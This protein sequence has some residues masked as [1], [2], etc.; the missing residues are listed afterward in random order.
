MARTQL[1][2]EHLFRR[3]GF[4]ASPGELAALGNMSMS[5]GIS[6]LLDYAEQPD[7][8]DSKIGQPNYINFTSRALSG[9]NIIIED[10]RQRWLFRMIHSQRPLQEKMALFWHNHFATAYSKIAGTFGAVQATKMLALREGDLPGPRGQ[11]ETFRAYALGNFRDLLLEM[12]KDPAMLVWL[13][14]R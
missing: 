14:G 8:V 4:G 10:A 5:Q 9:A 7:D 12:A 13:D 3:G 11:L 6:Y 2:L 1:H